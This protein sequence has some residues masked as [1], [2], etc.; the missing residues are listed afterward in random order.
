VAIPQL[1]ISTSINDYI[2]AGFGVTAPFGLSTDWDSTK[3][4]F[5]PALVAAGGHPTKSE[6]EVVDLSPT[7]AFKLNDNF[8]LSVGADY[9]LVR[10]VVFDA[11]GVENSGDGADWGWNAGLLATNGTWSFG[12]SYHSE[13]KVDIEGETTFPLGLAAPPTLP[14]TTV[15]AETELI[16]PW[17][18]QVGLRYK[19]TDALAVEFDVTRTGW[20]SFD[21][22]TIR[23]SI[24]NVVSNNNWKNANAYRLGVTY[25]AT[26]KMQLRF[27]YTLDKTGQQDELF[28]P[29]IPDEDR[30]LFSI[31]AGYDMGDGWN[32]DLGYM[33]VKFD[34]RTHVG[35]A[36]VPGQEANGSSAYNGDYEA[37]VHLFGVGLSKTF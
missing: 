26:P 21:A 9:Y 8:S 25:Q 16:I 7:I 29:R 30:Q 1:Q 35:T 37:D 4:V 17:R 6:L 32:L 11:N 33:Y 20:E 24:R 5:N 19:A 34:D 27:G 10:S 14:G 3:P 23:N 22:L 2:S 18:L 36:Y 31:G 13:T 12:V 28:S 15:D